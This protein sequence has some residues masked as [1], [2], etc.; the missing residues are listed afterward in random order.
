M[1]LRA[2]RTSGQIAVKASSVMQADNMSAEASRM[3]APPLTNRV[4]SCEAYS[5]RGLSGS[6]GILR[7]VAGILP[8][9][10]A[11]LRQLSCSHQDAKRVFEI[12]SKRYNPAFVSGHNENLAPLQAAFLK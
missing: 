12:F 6:A 4:Q 10:V 1:H 2:Q 5:F 11:R 3:P 8:A 7:A 9:S